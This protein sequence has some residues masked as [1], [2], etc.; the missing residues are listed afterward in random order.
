M[1][2]RRMNHGRW[3]GSQVA[4]HIEDASPGSA[5]KLSAI[6]V[7]GFFAN[8]SIWSNAEM[9]LLGAGQV[10]QAMRFTAILKVH[11]LQATWCIFLV[12]S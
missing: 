5:E 9:T 4:V 7:R 12:S 10:M 8:M 6:S 3:R 11:I 2:H 1:T